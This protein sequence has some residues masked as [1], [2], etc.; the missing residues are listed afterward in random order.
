MLVDKST[1]T[2]RR[3]IGKHICGKTKANK[4][5]SS[6]WIATHLLQY[7]GANPDATVEN[8]DDFKV[9]KCE[10]V[11]PKHTFWRERKPMKIQIKG[12]HYDR[13]KKLSKC[14]EEFK[15]RNHKSFCFIKWTNQSPRKNLTFTMCQTCISSAIPAF[16]KYRRPLICFYTC[17]LKGITHASLFQG[18]F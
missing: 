14:T 9:T 15:A 5:A 10:V 17:N 12:S 13:Y 7:Y 3:H 16:K 8:T 1:W 11:V 18:L 4:S 6:R 2:I